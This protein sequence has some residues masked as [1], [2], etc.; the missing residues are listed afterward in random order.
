MTPFWKG[1]TAGLIVGG[2]VAAVAMPKKNKSCKCMKHSAG[3]IL[4]SAGNVI[5]SLQSIL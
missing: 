4:K 5:D 1:M 3:K 2:T